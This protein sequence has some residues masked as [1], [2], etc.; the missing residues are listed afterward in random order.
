M[1]ADRK[2]VSK[3]GNEEEDFV[4]NWGGAVLNFGGE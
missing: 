2:G 4:A 3:E 1:D